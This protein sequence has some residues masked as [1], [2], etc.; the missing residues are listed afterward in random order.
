MD[1]KASWK[2]GVAEIAKTS[3]GFISGL[4]A[5]AST[6]SCWGQ[7]ADT[8]WVMAYDHKTFFN[9]GFTPCKAEQPLK[10]ME[11]QEKEA[12]KDYSIQEICLG[13]TYN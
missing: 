9:W 11:L 4:T 13:R 1:G 2:P 7:C 3:K 5:T 6:Q 8:R 12:Q 10:G